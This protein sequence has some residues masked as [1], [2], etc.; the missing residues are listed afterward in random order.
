VGV[1]VLQEHDSALERVLAEVLAGLV[2]VVVEDAEPW[3]L[4]GALPGFGEPVRWAV[5]GLWD[6]PAAAPEPTIGA[7]VAQLEADVAALEAVDPVGVSDAQLLGET[8]RLLVLGQRLRVLELARF[9]EVEQRTL[10]RHGG[11]HGMRGWL[12]HTAPDADH[13]DLTL[14]RRLPSRGHLQAAVVAGAV[15]VRSAREVTASLAKVERYLDAADGL[16]D[17]QAGEALV[18]QVVRNTV[19][20]VCQARGGLADDDPLLST[21]QTRTETIVASGTSQQDRVEQA[22][23]LLAT[24]LDPA[25]LAAALEQQTAA[26][27][28][29]LLEE[30]LEAAEAQRGASLRQREDGSW[31][32]KGRL[33]P[34]CGERL[35][36]ALAA[37]ARRDPTNP[38]D[39][40]ARDAAR[41][42]QAAREGVDLFTDGAPLPAWDADRFGVRDD[43]PLVPRTRSRR[44]HDALDGLLGRYLEQGLGGSHDKVPVQITLTLSSALPDGV[45]GALPARGATGRPLARSLV[46]R[47]WCDAHITALVM[48]RGW[49]PLGIAHTGRTL[50]GL[51]RTASLTQHDHRCAGL[52]CCPGRAGPLTDLVPHH[53]LEHSRHRRTSIDETV[54]L[55]PTAHHDIHTGKKRLRLRDGR[56]ID[57]NGELDDG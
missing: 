8:E 2:Q 39:T 19:D 4:P 25:H 29:N 53:L 49:K 32:L 48:S 46:R 54:W 21:L 6:A 34:E 24:H 5:P 41:R 52:D 18:A 3:H 26:I 27:L 44:L 28:P 30:Q 45:P 36:T 23:V 35:H 17:G 55:C 40:Q 15:P 9:R 20:L 7:L 31:D 12:A 43:E 10:F 47:W 38:L 42:E 11:F 13:R 33:T 51:E 16:V 37:E 56:L 14:A 50:R 1:S 22:F 57:E